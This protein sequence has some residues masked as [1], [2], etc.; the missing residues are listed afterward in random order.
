MKK[1]IILH[2][3]EQEDVQILREPETGVVEF[4]D[5]S[6]DC[7]DFIS[8]NKIHGKFMTLPLYDESAPSQ[9][10]V[11]KNELGNRH[12]FKV[13]DKKLFEILRDTVTNILKHVENMVII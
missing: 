11:F 10:I 8:D 9:H 2:W 7:R 13:K 12:F 3:N 6:T 5:S 1:Y 4:F